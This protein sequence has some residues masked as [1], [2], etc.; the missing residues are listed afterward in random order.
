VWR[1]NS[2]VSEHSHRLVGGGRLAAGAFA[3]DVPAFATAVTGLDG[4]INWTLGSRAIAGNV[5]KLAAIVAFDAISLT[6]TSKVVDATAFV[7]D[8]TGP[9]ATL[10]TAEPAK[11]ATTTNGP[12]ARTAKAALATKATRRAAKATGTAKA[13]GT[14]RAIASYM[15]GPT[16]GVAAK[17]RAAAAA[18]AA[19][20]GDADAGT[21]GLK[22]ADSVAGVA[23]LGISSSRL[24]TLVGFMARLLT[25]VAEA[26]GLGTG[27]GKMTDI[28]ALEASTSGERHSVHSRYGWG[29]ILS[30]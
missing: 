1:L 11:A 24:R 21:V 4:L 23:L 29:G 17:A 3:G 10:G 12:T 2:P 28:A 14:L 7:A 25:V 6:I 27:V 20:P 13:A 8:H 16:A 5:A 15:A 26:F 30:G 22:M 19:K 9:H 18:S